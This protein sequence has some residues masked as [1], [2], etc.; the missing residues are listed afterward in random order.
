MTD[1]NTWP[2]RPPYALGDGVSRAELEQL[3][4]DERGLLRALWNLTLIGVVLASA[5]CLGLWT[6]MGPR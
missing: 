3:H 2:T 5:F 4:Q 6:G 1:R